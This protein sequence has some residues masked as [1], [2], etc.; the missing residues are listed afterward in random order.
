[1]SEQ[2]LV[3]AVKL[4][5]NPLVGV[6]QA[7]A[8]R[9]D[10]ADVQGGGALKRLG[11]RDTT[12]QD[13]LAALRDR[14]AEW[15]ERAGRKEIQTLDGVS[16]ILLF[17]KLPEGVYAY[18]FKTA[19]GRMIVVLSHDIPERLRNEAVFH[20]LREAYWI[21]QGYT[22]H[23]AHIIASAEQ[24][25]KFSVDGGLTLL[26]AWLLENMGLEGLKDLTRETQTDRTEHHRIVA[27][28]KGADRVWWMRWLFLR[29]L[30][31]YEVRM[32]M[33]ALKYHDDLKQFSDGVDP[34]FGFR[35]GDDMAP[36]PYRKKGGKNVAYEPGSEEYGAALAQAN[37]EFETLEKLPDGER[38]LL[39]R[40]RHD[41][42]NIF[43]VTVDR[44]GKVVAV[45]LPILRSDARGEKNYHFR[46]VHEVSLRSPFQKALTGISMEELPEFKAPDGMAFMRNLISPQEIAAFKRMALR[47]PILR[48]LIL[49]M[50]EKDPQRLGRLTGIYRI[51]VSEAGGYYFP[52]T[53]VV[54]H[55]AGH[56]RFAEVMS[57]EITHFIH[58]ALLG[59]GV[60]ERVRRHLDLLKHRA[61]FQDLEDSELY[62][63]QIHIAWQ[64]SSHPITHTHLA[65]ALARFVGALASGSVIDDRSG[66]HLTYGDLR[67][68]NE[69]GLIP[70]EFLAAL[71]PDIH[72]DVPL[73]LNL[74]E[75]VAQGEIT[76]SAITEIEHV[77]AL[78]RQLGKS[79][80]LH[81]LFVLGQHG[82]LSDAVMNQFMGSEQSS[83][84]RSLKKDADIKVS[85]LI[86]LIGFLS[87]APAHDAELK[88]RLR[89]LIDLL[90]DPSHFP[91]L[92]NAFTPKLRSNMLVRGS[93][94]GNIFFVL[95]AALLKGGYSERDIEAVF[96][97]FLS[98]LRSS[99]HRNFLTRI[100]AR[101]PGLELAICNVLFV[102]GKTVEAVLHIKYA[103]SC[104]R[105]KW[106]R[107]ADAGEFREA[108]EGPD[109]PEH[110][111]TA[112]KNARTFLGPQV[113]REPLF[114]LNKTVLFL[115][116]NAIALQPQKNIAKL[117][118]WL[119]IWNPW[120]LSVPILGWL[121]LR[122]PIV[123]ILLS[124]ITRMM[125]NIRPA[126]TPHASEN[127]SA[128][129]SFWNQLTSGG[130][131]MA[132]GKVVA[133][134]TRWR[135]G[136]RKNAD[137]RFIGL[138]MRIAFVTSDGKIHRDPYMPEWAIPKSQDG[139]DYISVHEQAHLDRGIRDFSGKPF[140][141]RILYHFLYNELPVTLQPDFFLPSK[142]GVAVGGLYKRVTS[143]TKS[144]RA[145]KPH[146]LLSA[147]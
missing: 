122:V 14:H 139:R 28:A 69:L 72:D 54:V 133:N 82:L 104:P 53:H 96:S 20:E 66:Y 135:D 41:K 55:A 38:I 125:N 48:H 130:M 44:H 71:N 3:S 91:E 15:E 10:L 12:D 61:L 113:I 120:F 77:E 97:E 115:D 79:S 67:L 123:W 129:L 33:Q 128:N 111:F 65:E 98:Y 93:G 5:I 8:E 9:R 52:G 107:T 132:L 16:F 101:E 57:H 29:R 56:P 121:A 99:S 45:A 90:S 124:G 37:F 76:A 94:V 34:V 23:E 106:G 112:L 31:Q 83:F 62:R 13:A 60:N 92:E 141:G 118:D 21:S 40:S 11:R 24:M 100:G 59:E 117:E 85:D 4:F 74:F 49:T 50:L 131:R 47:N 51:G 75:A 119:K 46:V 108:L 25:E 137:K 64:Y 30:K 1:M 70:S 32:R 136:N 126:Q 89:Q 7:A 80:L 127:S 17:N 147:A 105:V 36:L 63:S 26:H 22:Q 88:T 18:H 39:A 81:Y 86:L 42:G 140:L 143:K 35:E 78:S 138:D 109:R 116:K 114:T 68:L 110:D 87:L 142:L 145:L 73:P 43:I 144:A 103:V 146:L 2:A 27:R 19:D 95:R 102:L 58:L 6:K 84:A 134:I